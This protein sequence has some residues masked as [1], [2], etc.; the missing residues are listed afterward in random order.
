MRLGN[1][2]KSGLSTVFQSTHPVWGATVKCSPQ[3]L[4]VVLFQSTHPVWGATG[5]RSTQAIEFGEFQ[6]THP[7]WGA[8]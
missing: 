7:V 8:T 5:Y 6:S 4:P 3:V 1:A 2:I